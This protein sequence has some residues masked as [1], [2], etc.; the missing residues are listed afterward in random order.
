MTG[1]GSPRRTTAR[2]VSRTG[3]RRH[4]STSMLLALAGALALSTAAISGARAADLDIRLRIDWGGGEPRSWQGT[5]RTTAGTLSEPQTLGLEADA[6][7]SMHLVARDTL[8][9]VPRTP[10]NYDGVD[11]RVRAPDDAKLVIELTAPD[12]APLDPIAIPLARVAKGFAQFDLDDDKNRLLARRKPGDTLAIRLGRESL[13]FEPGE[14]LEFEL[15]PQ[16][17]ELVSNST[18]Q[19]ES[20][21]TP[22]RSDEVI[23]SD[24]QDAKADSG[25][26]LGPIAMAIPLPQAEGVYDLKLALYPKKLTSALLKPEAI[27]QRKVQVVV[28]APVLPIDRSAIEW[29]T[30]YELDPANPSWLDRMTR[31][32]SLR[33]L[34]AIGPQQLTSGPT[35]TRAHLD[36]PWIE[37]ASGG[38]LAYPLTIE[39]PGQPHLLEIEY[40]SDVEQTLGIS[41]VEPNAA[42]QVQPIGL[43]SG[44]AVP[45]PA[46]G[47][48]AELARHRLLCWPR[49]RTPWV[50]LTNRR[51]DRPA[52]VG[53]IN[54]LAGPSEPPALAMAPS[55]GGGRTLA[56]YLD[57]PLLAENFSADEM[58]DPAARRTFDDW[59]TFY[60]AGQ[61][62]VATLKHGGYNAVVLSVLHEGGTLYPSQRLAPTPKYDSGTHFESG[63]D[64]IRKDVL[65]LILRL[66]DRAG[67]QVIP[68]VQFSA[69]LPEL[70]ALR[71]AGGNEAVG[72]EPIGPDGQSWLARYGAPRGLGVYYNALDDRVQQAVQGV[73]AE[74]A[75][76]YGQ[77]A[78]F[79][80][81]AI[82]WNANSYAIL[83]DETGSFDDA[84]IARFEQEAGVSIPIA[85]GAAPFDAR[86]RFLHGAG[87]KAWLGWRGERLAS[88]Y[89]GMQ[90]DLARVRNNARLYLLPADLLVDAQIQK[91][92]RPSLPPAENEAAVFQKLGIDLT[93]IHKDPRIVLPRPY[94]LSLGA[95]AG[96]QAL[97]GHWNQS[98]ALDE[99]FSGGRASAALHV[100]EPASLELPS[101]DRVSPFGKDKTFTW[102][103]AQ[104]SPAGAANRERLAHSI[105]LHDA[106]LL[107]DGGALLS[108]GQEEALAPLVKVFRRLPAEAF[109]TA[110]GKTDATGRGIT[111][112]TLSRGTKTWFYVVNDTPWTANVEIDF[113]GGQALR[114]LS[115]AEARKT[116]I[117]DLPSGLTWSITLEPYDLAGGELNSGR[118]RVVDYRSLFLGDPQTELH[119][120]ARRNALRTNAL[121]HELPSSALANPTFSAMP[122]A[123]EIPGWVFGQTPQGAGAISVEIDRQQG[124]QSMAELDAARASLHIVNRQIRGERAPALW[125]RSDPIKLRPTGRI[126][127]AAWMRVADPRQQPQLRLAIEGRRGGEVFYQ[128]AWIGL[129]DDGQPTQARLTT[130]WTRVPVTL[131]EVPLEGLEEIRVGIDLMGPGEVW[132]D[133][134]EVYDLS[135]TD[136]E[137][138][139]LIKIAG[140]ANAELNVGKLSACH[141]LISGY[142]P[143]FLE[144]HVPL[145]EPRAEAAFAPPKPVPPAGKG[146]MPPPADAAEP[147]RSSWDPRTWNLIPKSWR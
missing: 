132:V 5:I 105:A 83:P 114:I 144:K 65:E 39:S 95:A 90:S 78:S 113:E 50:L 97:L 104:I 136:P 46:A 128:F 29:K 13:V 44:F 53:K 96:Q 66:C 63:Q 9:I 127:V 8:Q 23:N 61:R 26:R 18:Y 38:W 40:P 85:M 10:R 115:Y 6:P 31:M 75:E 22:A 108:L 15:A 43:D 35:K 116:R 74:L 71:L 51:S 60:E 21:L 141:R 81:V 137:R 129:D 82:Q 7:G 122:K 68:A 146:P 131:T 69:P 101:F 126:T 80:G 94:R 70:E 11:L 16:V 34:P 111:V 33:R 1:Q 147:V 110:E 103:L 20:S 98:S 45:P 56:A 102:L 24:K 54:V 99:L 67:I 42:G 100:H 72:I 48:K 86:N 32:P 135:F 17:L 89:R 119:E 143:S 138:I 36:R 142:W 30:A 121:R 124:H 19:L 3:G 130:Q 59:V 27:A 139:E 118:A 91:A 134:V 125:V 73:V 93:A 57:R 87:A 64:P 2:E 4:A 28:V 112:R 120:Q 58:L 47:H 84:T 14:K 41:L 52:L 133:D 62:L 49:T 92:L 123:A 140:S 79:G 25:G 12:I 37:I 109:V 145:P 55:A 88:M 117:D 76:R 107:I 106:P 77:H